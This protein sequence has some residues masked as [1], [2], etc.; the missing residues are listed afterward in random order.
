MG[1][2]LVMVCFS[3]VHGAITLVRSSLTRLPISIGPFYSVTS[4]S[5]IIVLVKVTKRLLK[6]KIVVIME[7]VLSSV[8]TVVLFLYA[9]L[10]F[11]V[12]CLV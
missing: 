10:A 1:T 2:F 11:R 8:S 7:G 12:A 5:G 6:P 4:D 9:I 3:S